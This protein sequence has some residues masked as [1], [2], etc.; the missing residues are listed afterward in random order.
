MLGIGLIIIGT[1]IGL[2][3]AAPE[4]PVLVYEVVYFHA[5]GGG[6]LLPALDRAQDCAIARAQLHGTMP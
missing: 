1:F 3:A 5:A 2:F 6:E 4:L